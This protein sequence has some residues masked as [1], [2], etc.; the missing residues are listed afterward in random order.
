MTS[1]V[2]AL[3]V[4]EICSFSILDRVERASPGPFAGFFQRQVLAQA[5]LPN[6]LA[7][8]QGFDTGLGIGALDLQRL[9]VGL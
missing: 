3:N 9:A 5:D 8:L 7:Q 6:A 4:G 1:L 2:T